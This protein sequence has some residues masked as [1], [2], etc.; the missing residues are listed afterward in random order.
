[1][2]KQIAE[3]LGLSPRSVET[4]RYRIM[5]RLAFQKASELVEYAHQQ[6]LTGERFK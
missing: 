4:Y 2:S 1:T 6:G 5:H 3:K